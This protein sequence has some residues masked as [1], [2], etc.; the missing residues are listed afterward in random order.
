MGGCG[1]RAELR[2]RGVHDPGMELQPA[3]HDPVPARMQVQLDRNIVHI[4]WWAVYTVD[5]LC[6]GYTVYSV[7]A[8]LLCAL[9]YAVPN[10]FFA[11]R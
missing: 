9:H 8:A 1:Y 5:T 7:N 10:G 4:H 11:M 6:K 3:R 2:C